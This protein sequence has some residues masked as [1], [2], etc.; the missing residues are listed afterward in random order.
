MLL[1]VIICLLIAIVALIAIFLITKYNN[2]QWILIKL[3]KGE[4]KISSFLKTKYDILLRKF[5]FL[6]NN[7]T[8]DDDDFEEYKLLNTNISIDKLNQKTNDLNNLI[9]KY[10]DNN[11]ELYKNETI[12]KLDN[13]LSNINLSINS[14][15]K[16][17]NK[18]LTEYNNLCNLFPSKI[19]AFIFKYKPKNFIDEEIPDTL[20]IL[21]Q[22]ENS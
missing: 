2:F 20:K 19:I 3:N 14:S 7:I 15:K 22:E 9:N 18:H 6:K 11:E 10:L 1:I 13:E 5:E 21:N 8:I 4:N 12:I 17:Y 16:Y